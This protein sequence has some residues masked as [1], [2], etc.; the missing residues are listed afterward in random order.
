MT[1]ETPRLILREWELTDFE[2]YAA[3][4][5][6]PAVM[7][8]LS[9]TGTPMPRFAAWQGF[10][11]MVGHWQLRG[12]GFFA[13]TERE[14]GSF[15]GHVG[16]WNPEGWPGLEVGWVLRSEFWGRGYA[17]EAAKAAIAYAFTALDCPRVISL[18][19][20]DNEASKRVA[21]RVGERLDGEIHIAHH[22]PELKVL[23]FSI[24]KSDWAAS[25]DGNQL[26]TTCPS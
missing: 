17:A 16:P 22:P 5:A 12:F 8:F 2:P 20:P 9:L 24:S 3:M 25:S 21:G 13:V 6:D 10:S 26:A 1:L 14:T 7:K 19:H 23:Q 4:V 18:I 15:V 11:A